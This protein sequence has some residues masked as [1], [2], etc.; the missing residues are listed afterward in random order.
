MHTM[1]T[2]SAAQA[3][4]IT[5]RLCGFYF[6]LFFGLGAHLPLLSLY[7][8]DFGLSGVQIGSLLAAGPIVA[9]L[10]QPV[11]GMIS[12]RYQ[13]QKKVLLLSLLLAALAGIAFSLAGSHY[14][15][16]FPI[17]ILMVLFQ[18]AI[19][20]IIDSITL[21]HMRVTGGSY[22]SIRL[23]GALGFAVSVWVAGQLSGMLGL[24]SIFYLYAG[25]FIVCML[26]GGNLPQES[27]PL[28]TS[29]WQGLGQLLRIPQYLVFLIAAFLIFGPI[30]ANNSYFSLFYT[31]I[32]GTVAGVGLAF[33]LFAGSEAPIMQ[34]SGRFI[35]RFG[36][37]L[38][39]ILSGV[40]AGIRW[41]FYAG[42][43]NPDIVLWLFLL[44]GLSTGVF[45]PVAASYIRENTPRA[46]QVTAQ[47]IYAAVGNSLGTVVA[48]FIAGNLL[49]Q[50]GIFA[51]YKY[52]AVSSFLGSILLLALFMKQRISK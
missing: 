47:A 11:W 30:N 28:V 19:V 43:P 52:F 10:V 49:D 7:L 3:R 46:M 45:L 16:L 41:F 29:I 34:L 35:K 6:F 14:A 37:L 22:G 2:M 24:Q 31:A 48:S 40:V 18:S 23:F 33:L 50:F 27:L 20:P 36:M 15:I 39:L 12:D 21:S 38:M 8:A 42:E 32:G 51:S 25:S 9:I 44:Q 26:L 13:A 1:E 17:Y 5:Y 4:A